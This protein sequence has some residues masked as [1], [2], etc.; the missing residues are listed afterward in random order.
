M[1]IDRSILNKHLHEAAAEQ[2]ARDYEAKG[3]EVERNAHVGGVAVDLLARKGEDRLAFEFK[4]NDPW[5]S[6]P[7]FAQRWRD[8]IRGQ[9]EA[10]EFR[11]V[12]VPHPSVT[13]VDAPDLEA[14]IPRWVQEREADALDAVL[15][16]PKH[17]WLKRLVLDRMHIERSV[18][19]AGRAVLG[20]APFMDGE[21]SMGAQREVGVDFSLDT[22]PDFSDISEASTFDILS[23]APV[24]S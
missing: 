16:G 17:V 14:A 7:G 23:Y 19:V 2:F 13:E 21:V 22:D 1:Q 3:Y 12:Y 6:D 15:P 18:H 20:I 11:L 4:V 24:P 5:H 8:R 9:S 10:A